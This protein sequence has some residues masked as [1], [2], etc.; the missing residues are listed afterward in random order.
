[1]SEFTNSVDTEFCC[2]EVQNSDV[3]AG[4]TDVEANVT[5]VESERDIVLHVF[6]STG[7][8]SGTF[9]LLV[10]TE[11]VIETE[12]NMVL[13]TLLDSICVLLK[14]HFSM[15]LVG[16]LSKYCS[17]GSL[18]AFGGP[19]FLPRDALGLD[20]LYRP[21]G[22]SSPSS[23][24][25]F[26]PIYQWARRRA[27]Q[28]CALEDARLVLLGTSKLMVFLLEVPLQPFGLLRPF[29][30]QARLLDFHGLEARG[31]PV[32]RLV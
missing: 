13:G 7:D 16:A 6:L 9:G 14:I 31:L 12:L 2:F 28:L 3:E 29:D 27:D 1:M 8:F 32:G 5:N 10:K 11:S 20:F 18:V 22:W 21:L 15:D 4:G 25:A 30:P 19:I 26:G 17:H 23:F 24:S